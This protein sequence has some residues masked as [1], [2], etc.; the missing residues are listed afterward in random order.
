M[1]M[2]SLVTKS[3]HL[4]DTEKLVIKV[5]KK[6]LLILLWVVKSAAS[7]HSLFPNLEMPHAF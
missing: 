6:K 7:S 1:Q 2:I 5:K 3:D 4:N